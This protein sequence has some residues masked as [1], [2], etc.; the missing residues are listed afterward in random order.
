MLLCKIMLNTPD[1][2]QGLLTGKLG[3]TINIVLFFL[4]L[5]NLQLNIYSFTF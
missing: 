2:V 4:I 3:E 1:E 5:R